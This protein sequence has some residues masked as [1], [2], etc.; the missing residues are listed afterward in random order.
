MEIKVNYSY[1][2]DYVS[3]E[4][5]HCHHLNEFYLDDSDTCQECG[6]QIP[7]YNSRINETDGFEEI[8]YED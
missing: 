8:Y 6:Y 1:T 3:W 7:N 5:P 4:C 2:I